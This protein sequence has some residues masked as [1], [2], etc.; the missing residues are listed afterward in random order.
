MTHVLTYSITN[1]PSPHL[2]PERS[3]DLFLILNLDELYLFLP[4]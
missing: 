3:K 2:T 4:R 1:Q